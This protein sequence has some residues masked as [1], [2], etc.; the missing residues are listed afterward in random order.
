MQDKEKKVQ[1]ML[2]GLIFHICP[3]VTLVKY[4]ESCSH[5]HLNRIYTFL[6]EYTEKKF[7]YDISN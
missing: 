5:P 6:N 7:Y 3:L 1:K 2:I 4:H